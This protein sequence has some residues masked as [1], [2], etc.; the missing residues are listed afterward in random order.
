MI[1]RAAIV[2]LSTA[3]LHAAER[4]DLLR[5]T[6]GDQLHGSFLGILCDSAVK[7]PRATQTSL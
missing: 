2:V 3:A 1:R 5:F 4:P 6:N 7:G